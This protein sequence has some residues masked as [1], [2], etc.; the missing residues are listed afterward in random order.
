VSGAAIRPGPSKIAPKTRTRGE[1]FSL[2][3]AKTIA[4]AALAECKAK[5]FS[6]TQT[7][8]MSRPYGAHLSHEHT[9]FWKRTADR[10]Y[11][12]QRTSPTS[13]RPAA[14]PT[15]IGDDVIGCPTRPSLSRLIQGCADRFPPQRSANFAFSASPETGG[16][17]VRVQ[18]EEPISKIE[19]SSDAATGCEF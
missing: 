11:A 12:R 17:L 7:A 14:D 8:E 13:W 10:V 3:L 18:P 15:Q 1:T 2:G 6:T 4:E 16:L 5:G 9:E 19:S